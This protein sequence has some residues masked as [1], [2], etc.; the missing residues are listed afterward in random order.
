MKGSIA[1]V[2]I[3]GATANGQ[4]GPSRK[5]ED[6][7]LKGL[8]PLLTPELLEVMAA[9]GHGDELVLSDCNFPSD[10]VAAETVYG[11]AIRLAGADIGQAAKAIFS[12]FPLDS[13]VEAPILRMEMVGKPQEV[14]PVQQELLS[15]AR[16]NG[17]REW[18]M[19]SIERHAFYA[20][21]RRGFAVVVAMGE[22]RPYGCFVLV[23]GVI[24]PDGKVV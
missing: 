17:E 21:A 22:R 16:A 6:A 15:A 5:K 23:K 14:P 10:S 2:S 7:M 19:G 18:A 24:G 20:R 9:M 13:F 4:N 8:D 3:A 1:V 12:L 11:Q